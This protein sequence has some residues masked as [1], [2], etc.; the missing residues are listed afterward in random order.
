VINGLTPQGVPTL[1]GPL[2]KLPGAPTLRRR[3]R[4]RKSKNTR[5]FALLALPAVVGASLAAIVVSR[6]S[7]SAGCDTVDPIVESTQFT[8]YE[9]MHS[10]LPD[11][12]LNPSGEEAPP[13]P[14]DAEV[15]SIDSLHRRWAVVADSGAVYQYFL[16]SDIDPTLTLANFYEAGGIELD[17]DPVESKSESFVEYVLDTLDER[18]VKVEIGDYAGALSWGDPE[19]NGIRPHSLIWTD[20]QWNYALTA[21]RSPETVL[22]LGRN[23]VCGDK[24]GN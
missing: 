9:A 2:K 8:P 11:L 16:R 22:T 18:A 4:M 6:A 17:R 20:G 7:T 24:I 1:L 5:R 23:L 15:T 14:S 10:H 19:I 21:D 13:V 12:A 3:G